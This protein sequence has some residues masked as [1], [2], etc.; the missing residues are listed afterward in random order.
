MLAPE[1]KEWLA[2]FN[3]RFYGADFRGPAVHEWSTDER[4]EV[5]RDKNRAN[6]DLMTCALPVDVEVPHETVELEEV[7]IDDLAHL[8]WAEYKAAREAYRADPSPA[9]RVRLHRTTKRR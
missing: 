3:D 7:A 8:D 1:H 9:N 5:Y 2:Q 4:R 6:R